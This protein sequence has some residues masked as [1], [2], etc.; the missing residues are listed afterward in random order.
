[1]TENIVTGLLCVAWSIFCLLVG[2]LTSRRNREDLDA[3]KVERDR[4]GNRVVELTEA[5]EQYIAALGTA[6]EAVE[7]SKQHVQASDDAVAKALDA[8]DRA[9]QQL[10]VERRKSRELFDVVESVLKERDQWKQMWFA[11]GREH[12]NAQTALENAVV[13]AR[14]WMRSMVTTINAYRAEKKQE[15][16]GF[17]LDPKDKPVGTAAQFEALLEQAQREAPAEVDGVALRN[18]VMARAEESS[19]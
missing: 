3:V 1:M 2:Y 10:E 12:L 16:I 18:A 6:S 15:P 17:G 8:A 5:T 9:M 11:H 19:R 13:Q 7:T 14:V 4:L